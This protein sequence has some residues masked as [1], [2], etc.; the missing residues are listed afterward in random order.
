MYDIYGTKQ[1][2]RLDK[3]IRDHCLYAPFQM[4]NNFSYI[5]TLPKSNEIMVAQSGQTLGTYNLQN[6]E[7]EY[8][9]FENQS[10]ANEVS[11]LYAAG[12]S[13][14]FEYVTLGKTTVWAAAST[15]INENI[16]ILRKPMKAIVMLFTKDTRTD[17]EEF[18]YPNISEV[19]L[20][21][22]GV[23][24][25]IYSQGINKSRFYE[26]A[27]RSFGS[28]DLKDQ[29]MTPQKFYKDK[30]ALVVDLRSNEE[31]N[32]TGIGKKIVNT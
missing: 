9:R 31:S 15:L 19:K 16:N 12:R 4:N 14:F 20:T 3:I 22:E 29:F 11:S 23:P 7:L 2:I 17:S 26:E 6:I 28:K 10:V 30:F 25:Q 18:V 21:I 32:K 8:E 13:L 24:N 27:M 5:I 1:K